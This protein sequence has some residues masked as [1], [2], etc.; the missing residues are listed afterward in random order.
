MWRSGLSGGVAISQQCEQGEQRHDDEREGCHHR[1]LD[2]VDCARREAVPD[3]DV[4]EVGLIDNGGPRQQEQPRD[5]PPTGEACENTLPPAGAEDDPAPGAMVKP[6]RDDSLVRQR[7][8]GTAR[9]KGCGVCRRTG[10][11]V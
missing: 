11:T 4:A 2:G 10:N 3:A 5:Q 8:Q 1:G 6:A 7:G 9:V